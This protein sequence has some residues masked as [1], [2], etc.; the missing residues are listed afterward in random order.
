MKN[1]MLNNILLFA[2]FIILLLGNL[3]VNARLIEDDRDLRGCNHRYVTI[4][5]KKS[6]YTERGYKIKKC[7]KCGATKKVILKLK[8]RSSSSSNGSDS[9][10]TSQDD[11]TSDNPTNENN[12]I[13]IESEL[14]K[15]DQTNITEVYEN[16]VIISLGKSISFEKLVD[17]TTISSSDSSKLEIVDNSINTKGSGYVT[18]TI[19]NGE[20]EETI[21][22]FIWN[23]YLC[24]SKYRLYTNESRS[25]KGSIIYAETYL[26]VEKTSKSKTF[27]INEHLFV[28]DGKVKKDE[29]DGKYIKSYYNEKNNKS[30]TNNFKYSFI[31]DSGN[32]EPETNTISENTV[33]DTNTINQNTTNTVNQNT[34][35]ENTVNTNTTDENVVE[36][37][38]TPTNFNIKKTKTFKVSNHRLSNGNS[39]SFWMYT[40]ETVTKNM[41]LIVFLHGSGECGKSLDSLKSRL[42]IVKNLYN[43]KI[44]VNAIIIIPACTN[45]STS[46]VKNPI[47]LISEFTNGTFVDTYNRRISVDKNKVA[48]IGFSQG[49]NQA[50]GMSKDQ[51]KVFRTVIFGSGHKTG[52]ASYFASCKAVLTMYGSKESTCRTNMQGVVRKINS[53]GGR[54]SYKEISGAS[55]SGMQGKMFGDNT[56]L[57]WCLNNM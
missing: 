54:A 23:A 13:G 24:K 35:N 5:T 27:K 25:K 34:T 3:S 45:S 33:N 20:K 16:I 11:S 26:S 43:H 48:L 6:T 7:N 10:D 57:N 2:V 28:R 22:V 37:T 31:I 41:P 56:Y 40:P 32:E 15:F 50:L 29:L 47:S 42:L 9:G 17:N 8:K 18:L 52:N 19:K 51:A 1:K 14:I 44:G 30:K 38:P 21:K 53:A 12:S 46:Y 36:P 49:T 4:S 39:I 55:H